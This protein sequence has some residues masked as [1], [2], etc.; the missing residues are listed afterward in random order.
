MREGEEDGHWFE[1]MQLSRLTLDG[2]LM[3]VSEGLPGWTWLDMAGR[4]ERAR[5]FRMAAWA[6]GGVPITG[7]GSR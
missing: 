1:P 2:D 4:G 7:D 3:G 6:A 5:L